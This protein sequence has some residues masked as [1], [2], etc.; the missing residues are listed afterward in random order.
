MTVSIRF[1]RWAAFRLPAGGVLAAAL[2][3]TTAL[4]SHAEPAK[5]PAAKT[6]KEKPVSGAKAGTA[7]KDK[8]N[9]GMPKQ[10]TPEYDEWL[11]VKY[12]ILDRFGRESAVPPMDFW[13]DFPPFTPKL[14]A[15][16]AR[17]P[18]SGQQPRVSALFSLAY[19]PAAKEAFATCR[20]IATSD[21]EAKFFKDAAVGCLAEGFP[22]KAVP[23]LKPMAE[24]K[25]LGTRMSAIA[26]L[27]KLKTKEADDV[28]NKIR[29]KVTEAVLQMII[30]QR[31][32][33]AA[34]G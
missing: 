9:D 30:D 10:G 8:S 29:P 2:L 4:P 5:A 25:E 12:R 15:E 33:E 11:R 6:K 18:K 3:G 7:A 19:F 20:D 28:L 24:S 14:L 17:E 23:I 27:A 34:G 16:I 22:D 31:L 21:T 26:G 13:K 32:K 1:N